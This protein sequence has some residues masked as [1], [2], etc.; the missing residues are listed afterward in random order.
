M[1]V[2]LNRNKIL[3]EMQFSFFFYFDVL[4]LKYKTFQALDLKAFAGQTKR[5]YLD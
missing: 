1:F 3:P 2:N 4:N 5:L